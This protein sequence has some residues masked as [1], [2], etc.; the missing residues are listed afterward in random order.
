MLMGIIGNRICFAWWKFMV[1][2]SPRQK[3]KACIPQWSRRGRGWGD[4]ST[5][6]FFQW[7]DKQV[8][9]KIESQ[10]NDADLLQESIIYLEGKFQS[11]M[12]GRIIGCQ[13]QMNTSEFFLR[14]N[15]E[16]YSGCFPTQIIILLQKT[17][18]STVSSKLVVYALMKMQETT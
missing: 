18:M 5:P 1:R 10:N 7:K 13:A 11:D 3:K 4:F 16:L 15:L 12:R 14:L 6:T 9:Q 2:V 17:R 8:K